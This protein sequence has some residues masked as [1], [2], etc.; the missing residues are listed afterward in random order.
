AANLTKDTT[1]P[2]FVSAEAEGTK[3]VLKYDEAIL[4]TSVQAIDASDIALQYVTKD[5]VLIKLAP[6]TDFTA[7]ATYGKDLNGNGQIDSGTEEVKYVELNLA[8]VS[9][10]KNF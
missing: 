5:G 10:G 7:G 4:N 2:K 3:L 8:E 1:A 6:T 9:G